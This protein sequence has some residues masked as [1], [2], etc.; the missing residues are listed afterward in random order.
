MGITAWMFLGVLKFVG[1]GVD[2][3]CFFLALQLL[4]RWLRIPFLQPLNVIGSDLVGAVSGRTGKV[5]YHYTHRRLSSQGELLI[6][7]GFFLVF[8]TLLSGIERLLW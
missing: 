4:M 6:G 7:L 1:I 3:T 2:V 5:W 8:G